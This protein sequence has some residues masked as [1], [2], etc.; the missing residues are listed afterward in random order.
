MSINYLKHNDECPCGSGLK[1]RECCI[2]ENAPI[3]ERYQGFSTVQ[4]NSQI[5]DSFG[6]E[7]FPLIP[8]TKV[9]VDVR[10]PLQL[11]ANI[12]NVLDKYKVYL[13]NLP[14][15]EQ[16]I[17]SFNRIQIL[18]DNLHA[19]KYHQK[20]FL[21]RLNML[22]VENKLQNHVFGNVSVFMDDMPLRYELEAFMTKSR[23]VLD[24]LA[25]LVSS[26]LFNI[27]KKHGELI[28]F[29]KS[30]KNYKDLLDIYK[31]AES[32]QKD[33]KEVR[34]AIEH[35]GKFKSFRTF[36]HQGTK[37]TSPI[38]MDISSDHFCFRQWNELIAFIEAVLSNILKI[39]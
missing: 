10:K 2:P 25:R 13:V 19:V 24:V 1:V 37:V 20:Q 34:D 11:N 31:R 8:T 28:N 4:L 15:N 9:T 29:L 5:V 6:R 27:S 36:N 7:V 23:T 14:K 32:W 38:L 18:D 39:N 30:K 22:Q 3:S 21:Y 26:I 17:T 33:A 35:E 12:L 16:N